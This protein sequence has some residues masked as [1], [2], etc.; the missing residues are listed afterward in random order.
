MFNY[1]FKAC[2]ACALSQALDQA[3]DNAGNYQLDL[4]LIQRRKQKLIQHYHHPEILIPQ[5]RLQNIKFD[6]NA[7]SNI[8][9]QHVIGL[10]FNDIHIGGV[11]S[12]TRTLQLFHVQ[13]TQPITW[14]LQDFITD[15][16]ASSAPY[17]CDDA[18][19]SELKRK[20]ILLRSKTHGLADLRINENIENI[21]VDMQ[22]CHV[23][24]IQQKQSK[25][26]KFDGKKYY[27]KAKNLLQIDI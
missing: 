24:T 20:F 9:N 6:V 5:T 16:S 13:P 3:S 17:Q 14:V 10:A 15:Q 27:F 11:N 7:F 2:F 1:K 25:I 21:H 19:H 23:K 18:Q 8:Q 22:N 4:F 26:L 12:S